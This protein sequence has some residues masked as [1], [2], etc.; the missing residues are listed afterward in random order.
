MAVRDGG[1]SRRQML[2]AGGAIAVAVGGCDPIGAVGAFAASPMAPRPIASPREVLAL[3]QGWRFFE[4]DIPFPEI[5]S[6]DD[7]YDNAKAGKAWGAAAPSFD[8]SDW[9][10]VRLPHDFVSFQPIEAD[11]NRAQGYRRRG[12]AWY[13]TVL[14]F[15]PADQGRH[16][17]LQIDGIA[18]HA[19]LWF[20]GTVVD[21]NW[22]GYNGIT[23]DLTPFATFG[24]DLNTLAIRVDAHA[25]EGW[26]YEG[27]GLYRPVR[28]V[29][30]DPVHIITDGVYAHPVPQG[31]GWVLPVE[32]T[33]YNSGKN[34]AAMMVVSTLEDA[35]GRVVASGQAPVSITP[36]DQGVA[37]LDLGV[38]N[39]RLWSV[40]APTLYRVQTR[41]MAGDRCVD[42]VTT[43]CGFRTTRFDKDKGFFLNGRP[44]KIKGVCVHQDHA[45]VGTAIPDALWDYRIRRLKELGC[46]AIRCTHN[47]PSAVV[48]DLCDRHGL[49]VMDENRQFNPSPDTLAQL[50]WMVRRDRNHPSVI[51]WSVFNEEP[52]Q[53]SAAGYEMV[54]RMAHA[55]KALD[56]TRPV[57]AAMNGGLFT[58]VN[59]SQ[60]VDVVGFNYQ[61]DKYDAFHAAHPDVPLISSEDTSAFSTRGAYV[62]DKDSRTIAGYDD[63]V[64]DWNTHRAAWKAIA[65]RDFIAGGFVWTGFDYHGEP[66]PW[67]WPS[68]SSFYGIM[69]LCGFAKAAFHIHQ[70]QWVTDRPVLALVPHWNWAGREGRPVKVMACGNMEE[71]EL[72]LNGRSQGRQAVDPYEMNHW[73]VAYAPGRL[74]AVGYAGGK[75]TA[76]AQVETTGPA[77]ALRLTPD[78]DRLRGDGLDATPVM[79]EAIDAQGRPVPLAQDMVTFT[80]EGGDIIGLGNGDP[81]SAAPEKGT[82]RALF[83]GLA[84][85]IVQT[86]AGSRGALT[87]TAIAPG[88]K[89][90]SARMAVEAAAAPTEQA[91]APSDLILDTWYAAPPAATMEGALAYRDADMTAWDDFGTRWAHDPQTADGYTLCSVR[92][93]PQAKVGRQ[94][95]RVAFL[96]LVGSCDVYEGGRLLG[97]KTAAPPGPLTVALAPG[98]GVRRLDVVFRT[99]AGAEFGFSRNVAVRQA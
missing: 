36:L 53:G 82:R 97:R 59:V 76:R 46:N 50:E 66:S 19:T 17:E 74:E 78:R 88:L 61:Q 25:M 31:D 5:L 11:A 32:V 72:F 23:I 95:G 10:D 9:A 57:T 1:I 62:T 12:I 52:M 38:A 42:A 84:Q 92:F 93:T 29:K 6:Q 86:R 91:T 75:V 87:L 83:N 4:G 8:D 48:L 7:S 98:A 30:R 85:V 90:A 67:G 18:T 58:P 55:V 20:N 73:M 94:G 77:A 43:T 96:S 15:D 69:D 40:E 89:S 39:P 80:I 49:L 60:A 26:W 64:K 71:V 41:L 27:G 2:K 65:T 99:P 79:V 70:A 54:R 13:R 56:T 37:R 14:R 47:A 24:D 81:N 22:S 35:D 16:I 51:L 63:P 33:A 68:N 28:I 21:R 45:G 3:D 34:P 44:L